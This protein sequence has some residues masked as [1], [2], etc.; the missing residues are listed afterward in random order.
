M[1][2]SSELLERL[3]Q[4]DAQLQEIYLKTFPAIT[5]DD[6]DEFVAAARNNDKLKRIILLDSKV[7]NR[8]AKALATLVNVEEINLSASEVSDGG[9]E[10]LAVMP[11]LKKLNLSGNCITNSGVIALSHS[12]TIISLNLSFNDQITEIGVKE[13]LQNKVL[14][15]LII[16]EEGISSQ[17]LSQLKQ[18]MA[19]SQDISI[20]TSNIFGQG[21]KAVQPNINT[22]TGNDLAEKKQEVLFAIITIFESIPQE[23]RGAFKIDCQKQFNTLPTDDEHLHAMKAAIMIKNNGTKL[24]E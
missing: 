10:A 5:D 2:F 20:A 12:N 4:N 7:S 9:A 11:K 1:P 16:D 3:E 17:L 15:E 24:V 19:Q 22:I 14:R 13:F 6:I 23:Q 18:H 8:G 21:N